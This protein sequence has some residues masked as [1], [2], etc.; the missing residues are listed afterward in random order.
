LEPL[1]LISF[2]MLHDKAIP[3][4]HAFSLYALKSFLKQL[5][6]AVFIGVSQSG[7]VDRSDAKMIEILG[8]RGQASFNPT[9]TIHPGQ[10]PKEHGYKMI[11]GTEATG[12]VFGSRFGN[13]FLKFMSRKHF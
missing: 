3:I 5:M 7:A 8:L 10:L 6:A 12:V 9:Q 13:G 1:L 4:N 2:E 11:P